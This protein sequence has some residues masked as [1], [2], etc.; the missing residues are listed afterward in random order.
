MF[1]DWVELSERQ[2]AGGRLSRADAHALLSVADADLLEARLQAVPAVRWRQEWKLDGEKWEG[3]SSQLHLNGGA[4]RVLH[5]DVNALTVFGL[6]RAFERALGELAAENVKRTHFELPDPPGENPK[7][8]N[9][10]CCEQRDFELPGPRGGRLFG[11]EPAPSHRFDFRFL[12]SRVIT[13]IL[14]A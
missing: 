3:M 11:Q 5:V 6:D 7:Q 12:M 1:K 4:P 9:A 14:R 8:E 13:G 2:L 10:A